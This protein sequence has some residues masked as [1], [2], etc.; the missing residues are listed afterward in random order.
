VLYPAGSSL[1]EDSHILS[2]KRCEKLMQEAMAGNR[3]EFD[4]IAQQLGSRLGS[5]LYDAYLR[6]SVS[7]TI[8]RHLFL[9]HIEEPGTAWQV[10][11]EIIRR[12]ESTRK[13]PSASVR[14]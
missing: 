13:K 11:R 2:A 7:R 6:G 12:T 5:E 3:G 14:G 10:C 4:E 9:A 8:L 1:N